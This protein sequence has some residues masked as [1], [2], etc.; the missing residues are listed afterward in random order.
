MRWQ[1]IKEKKKK[2]KKIEY[3]V[4]EALPF[5]HSCLTH[6][7]MPKKKLVHQVKMAVKVTGNYTPQIVCWGNGANPHY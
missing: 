5:F 3:P 1:S 2:R 7:L 4:T 6:W